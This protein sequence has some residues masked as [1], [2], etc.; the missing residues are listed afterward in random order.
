M[1][2]SR[3]LNR[4]WLL[5]S[6]GI[7]VGIVMTAGSGL[8]LTS[9]AQEPRLS[10]VSNTPIISEVNSGDLSIAEK[11]S[12]VFADAADK[13]NPSVVTVF[14][15]T[16]VKVEGMPFSGPPFEGFFGRDDFFKKFFQQRTPEQN[17]S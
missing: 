16:N 12:N 9:H 11:L 2:A 7:L 6:I 8:T 17:Y 5:I 13:V 10:A 14:T 3:Y 15:E 1:R 4:S